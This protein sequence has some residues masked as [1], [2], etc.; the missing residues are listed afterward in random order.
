MAGSF[1]RSKPHGP[2]SKVFS[3]S[4]AVGE[5]KASGAGTDCQSWSEHNVTAFFV[6]IWADFDNVA[7]SRKEQMDVVEA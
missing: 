2:L 4:E 3:M 5:I 7:R 6:N 1:S